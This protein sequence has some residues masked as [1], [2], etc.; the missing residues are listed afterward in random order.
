[1]NVK[2][3]TPLMA[4]FEPPIYIGVDENMR[5]KN[6]TALLAAGAKVDPLDVHSD[7]VLDLAEKAEYGKNESKTAIID[8]LVKHGARKVQ[9]TESQTKITSDRAYISFS[10]VI[11]K[12]RGRLPVA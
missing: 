2:G 5:A 9:R 6:V 7:S 11:G 8:V 3:C 12:S 1:M 4:C 10:I